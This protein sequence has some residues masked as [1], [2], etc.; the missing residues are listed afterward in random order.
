MNLLALADDFTAHRGET[1]LPL[2][3]PEVLACA[4][5]ATRFYMG[6]GL[7]EDVSAITLE[8][9]T[10]L[11]DL[12]ASEWAIIGPLFRLYVEREVSLVVEA[13]R[14]SGVE[15]VGRSSSEVA[16]EIQQIEQQLPH[17]AYY[18]PVFTAGY[19]VV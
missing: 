9:V 18:E 3:Q 12:S 4:I 6:W 5:A 14:A 1:F 17:L 13:S 7:L 2:G 10:R 19:P 16:G 15:I 8:T 11:T